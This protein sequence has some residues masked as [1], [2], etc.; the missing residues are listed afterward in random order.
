MSVRRPGLRLS[1]IGALASFMAALAA[2]A[3]DQQPKESPCQKLT[4]ADRAECERRLREQEQERATAPQPDQDEPPPD[5]K[6]EGN[7]D[8]DTADPPQP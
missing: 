8:S 5:I 4:G 6:S 3:A 2:S 1:T 7:D